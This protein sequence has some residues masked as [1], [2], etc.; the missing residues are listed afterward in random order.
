[1]HGPFALP[2]RLKETNAVLVIALKKLLNELVSI[3]CKIC[4]FLKSS[5]RF[6]Y[7]ESSVITFAPGHQETHV[8]SGRSLSTD[9]IRNWEH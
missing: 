4:G 2:C 7:S 5:T 3:D 1:M 8:L 6:A 9:S